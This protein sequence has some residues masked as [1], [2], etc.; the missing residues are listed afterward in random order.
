[1]RYES[2]V[3]GEFSFDEWRERAAEHFRP[4][5]FWELGPGGLIGAALDLATARHQVRGGADGIDARDPELV[6]LILD[7]SRAIGERYFRWTASGVENVPVDGPALLVGNHNGGL[8]TFDSLLT[9]VAIRD[10]VGPERIVHPLAHDILFQRQRLRELAVR[11]GALRADHE[12]A[13]RALDRGRLVLVYPGSDLDSTRRFSDRHRI[14]L[15]GRTGFLELALRHRVPI[16]PVVSVGTHE[17]FIV[18]SRGDRLARALGLKRRLRAEVFPIVFSLPWGITSGFL[19]YIPLPAQTSLRFGSPILLGDV[20][21]RDPEA[22]AGSYERV[23]SRMQDE[24]DVL[25][26]GRVPFLGSIDAL[27]ARWR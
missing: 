19:P 25:A 2:W 9:V 6:E 23:R 8:Q 7:L 21:P 4:G 16:I 22:L 27:L 12:A 14:E 13:S 26:H 18:L 17:Q 10:R 24:L 5:D 11:F 15:G 20:D 3:S 1:M